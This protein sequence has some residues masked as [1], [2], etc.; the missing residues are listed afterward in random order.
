M[1]NTEILLFASIEVAL[2]ANA[3]KPSCHQNEEKNITQLRWQAHPFKK[4]VKAKKKSK[5][6]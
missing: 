2:E 6:K 3:E 1:N 5:L 4:K